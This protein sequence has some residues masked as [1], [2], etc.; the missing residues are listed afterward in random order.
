MRGRTGCPLAWCRFTAEIIRMVAESYP[1]CS[2]SKRPRVLGC[3][4][5]KKFPGSV[6]VI[7]AF[8]SEADCSDGFLCHVH[9]KSNIVQHSF[10]LNAKM[11]STDPGN[12]FQHFRIQV[13]RG[14]FTTLNTLDMIRLPIRIISAVKRHHAS[15]QPVLRGIV[16]RSKA[17]QGPGQSPQDALND[18]IFIGG[19]YPLRS[20]SSP[21]TG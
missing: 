20:T 2:A 11:T 8:N 10:E 7:L 14:R 5:L 6:L 12:F 15:G 1:T 19:R 3:G 13:H 16:T 18:A 4:M 21:T 17:V 9:R